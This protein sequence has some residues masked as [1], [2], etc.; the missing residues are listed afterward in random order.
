[1]SSDNTGNGKLGR[2]FANLRSHVEKFTARQK[3]DSP[4]EL[5]INLL[6]PNPFQPRKVF[7]ESEIKALSDSIRENGLLSPIIVRKN[8]DH[9]QIIAGERRWRAMRLLGNLK[10]PVIVR[11]ASKDQMITLSIIENIQRDDLNPIELGYA[12]KQ[13]ME[14]LDL[15]QEQLAE[16]L[17]R[18]R[19]TVTNFIRL[20]SLDPTIQDYVSRET[21]TMGHARALLGIKNK[22]LQTELAKEIIEKNLNVRQT[23]N[24]VKEINLKDGQEAG[25]QPVAKKVQVKDVEKKLS[26]YFGTKVQIKNLKDKKKLIIDFYDNEDFNRL[27]KLFGFKEG[28]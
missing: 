14:E 10:V 27:T 24:K 17:G 1:M 22:L 15:T 20:L 8:E 18:D 25:E 12:F 19:S 7:K 4:L 3:D 5:D 21:L 13:M 6:R 23:E 9:Y 11:E 28:L 16:K 26:S 2:G